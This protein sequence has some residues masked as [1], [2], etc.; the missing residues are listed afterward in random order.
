VWDTQNLEAAP[1]VLSG[2]ES[3]ILSVAYSPDGRW[4]TSGSGDRTL[5]VWDTQNLE[6][7]PRVLSGH[8][9]SVWS[10]AYSPDGRCLASG[11]GDR[12]VRVWLI[13][14]E[15]LA[16]IGCQKVLRNLTRDEWTR[17]LGDLPYEKTCPQWP[18]GE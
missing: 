10:V 2:H 5:R 11:S 4:L 18:E 13:D 3:S 15:E 17:Y 9:S 7:A 1:R 12:T 6:A 14:L 8:E 16:A